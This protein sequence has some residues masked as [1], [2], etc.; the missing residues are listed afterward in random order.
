MKIPE[1]RERETMWSRLGV[2][3]CMTGQNHAN[4]SIIEWLSINENSSSGLLLEF[5]VLSYFER[6]WQVVNNIQ[7]T[8]ILNYLC[9]TCQLIIF[10]ITSKRLAANVR[11][12]YWDYHFDIFI[13][14]YHVL[15][16]HHFLLPFHTQRIVIIQ[17][18]LKKKHADPVFRKRELSN[19]KLI[20]FL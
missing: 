3:L 6:Q 11:K 4:I 18:L 2:Y 16:F 9:D 17:W 13:I 8:K 19:Y 7:L 14:S 1:D 5:L 20:N 10:F 15:K 12:C